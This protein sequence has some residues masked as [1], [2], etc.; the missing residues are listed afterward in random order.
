MKDDTLDKDFECIEKKSSGSKDRDENAIQLEP[1]TD[2]INE[3]DEVIDE[4]TERAQKVFRDWMPSWGSTSLGE[5]RA[6][7]EI[8]EF[9]NIDWEFILSRRITSNIRLTLEERWAPP[10][11]KIAWLYPEVLLPA[12]HQVEQY[13]T[14]VLMA[15]DTSGSISRS[16]LDRFLCVARSIPADR[17]LLTAISFDTKVYP[18]DIWENVPVIRGGGGTSFMAVE[19][20]ATQQI[21]RYPDLVVVLTDGYA[22]RPVIQ[23]PDR[24]F[25]LITDYGITR[26]IEGV[27]RYCKMKCISSVSANRIVSY[28]G[29]KNEY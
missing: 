18:V 25:W 7:G 20:F 10:N 13:Q 6:I 22:P 3:P 27:G 23:H 8:D 19:T 28:G 21:G 9:V 24:W 5:L 2:G 29:N 14:S 4:L 16:V 26:H 12:D 1:D 15:I 11:R 17:V